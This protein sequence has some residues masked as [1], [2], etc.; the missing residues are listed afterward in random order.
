M[1]LICHYKESQTSITPFP[2]WSLRLGPKSP[3]FL[4]CKSSH[5]SYFLKELLIRFSAIFF[6]LQTK[7][8][9]SSAVVSIFDR[10]SKGVHILNLNV[11][12]RFFRVF[13][14]SISSNHD[15]VPPSTTDT[16]RNLVYIPPNEVPP[17]DIC[18]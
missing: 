17:Q 3:I 10:T 9:R 5:V 16:L 18:D 13:T 7:S 11:R 2:L 8:R 1:L 15:H 14:D 12:S 6:N 4:K